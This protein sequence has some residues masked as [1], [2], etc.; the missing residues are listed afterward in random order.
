MVVQSQHLGLFS[1]VEELVLFAIVLIFLLCSIPRVVLNAYEL[2]NINIIR[3]NLHN[4]CFRFETRYRL[5]K[6]G[7]L[8][9]HKSPARSI[10]I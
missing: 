9:E 6:V 4:D 8:G 3:E 5:R 10:I 2:W 1:T 7:H